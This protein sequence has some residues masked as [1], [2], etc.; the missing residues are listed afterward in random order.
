[1]GQFLQLSSHLISTFVQT[2][3]IKSSSYGGVSGQDSIWRA[4]MVSMDHT[5]G[6]GFLAGLG[7]MIINPHNFLHLRIWDFC[8]TRDGARAKE[9]ML[10]FRNSVAGLTSAASQRKGKVTKIGGTI[11]TEPG[12]SSCSVVKPTTAVVPIVKPITAVVAIVRCSTG[13]ELCGAMECL[14]VSA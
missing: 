12:P 2:V 13:P 7:D 9:I 4:T 6:M 8:H 3:T 1:M 11:V 14:A 10:S 5:L